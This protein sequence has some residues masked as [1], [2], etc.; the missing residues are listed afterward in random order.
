MLLV[1]EAT[2]VALRKGATRRDR[3]TR[4]LRLEVFVQVVMMMVL[5]RLWAKC[6]ICAIPL[7][8]LVA[9]SLLW[10]VNRAKVHFNL[11]VWLNVGVVKVL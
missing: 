4:D 6:E 9:I 1:V 5:R 11:A 8:H 3:L 7:Q 2:E 10:I